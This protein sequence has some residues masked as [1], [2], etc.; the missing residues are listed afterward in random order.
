MYFS[1]IHTSDLINILIRNTSRS[2]LLH[3]KYEKTLKA[4]SNQ[5]VSSKYRVEPEC[6][7]SN[8]NDILNLFLDILIVSV[9]PL[10]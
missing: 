6:I 9:T 3:I 5:R 1:F 4:I 7:K 8:D 10:F 2:F